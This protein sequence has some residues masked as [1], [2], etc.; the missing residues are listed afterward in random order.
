[1]VDIILIH[2]I[3][4][5]SCEELSGR[6]F[7]FIENN[8]WNND[9]HNHF[10]NDIKFKLKLKFKRKFQS[11]KFHKLGTNFA[12]Y[13]HITKL[14]RQWLTSYSEKV[15]DFFKCSWHEK[16]SYARCRRNKIRTLIFEYFSQKIL[17]FI[18]M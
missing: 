17:H 15:Y 4:S 5:M 13:C 14:E 8:N 10:A 11:R 16:M 2:M 3:W 1:M 6:H 7:R 18:G 12:H 9:S